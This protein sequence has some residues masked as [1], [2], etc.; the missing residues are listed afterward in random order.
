MRVKFS[1]VLVT[2]LAIFLLI[3]AC[4]QIITEKEAIKIASEGV[5]VSTVERKSLITTKEVTD[6]MNLQ[7]II[8]REDLPEKIWFIA[9]YNPDETILIPTYLDAETGEILSQKFIKRDTGEEIKKP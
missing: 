7:L 8:G 6:L 4:G 1:G 3:S 5:E 9:F 2:F